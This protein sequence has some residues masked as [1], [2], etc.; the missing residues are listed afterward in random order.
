METPYA[1]YADLRIM[2][3]SR[4]SGFAPA[5]ARRLFLLSRSVGILAHSWEESRSGRRIKGPLPPPLL[6]TYTGEQER[7]IAARLLP[8]PPET[9]IEQDQPD[10]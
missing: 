10:T 1:S 5:L 9:G 7:R 6:P 8:V 4:S 3:R 2:P